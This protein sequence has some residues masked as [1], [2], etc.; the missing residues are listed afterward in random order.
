MHTECSTTQVALRKLHRKHDI[1]PKEHGRPTVMRLALHTVCTYVSF[2][3]ECWTRTHSRCP[4]V[5]CHNEVYVH[6]I[7]L[8]CSIRYLQ[9][10]QLND[11]I[12]SINEQLID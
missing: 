8:I 2:V 9:L 6:R 4:A 12:S 5:D 3:I 10:D 11:G 1:N 7:I